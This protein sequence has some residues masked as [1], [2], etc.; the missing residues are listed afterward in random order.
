[1]K[2]KFN[3]TELKTIKHQPCTKCVFDQILNNR[4]CGLLPRI[5]LV[6]S[7]VYVPT[8]NF[9][10]IFYLDYESSI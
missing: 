9:S 10:D 6:D 8:G 7:Q 5:C 4:Y 1:M 3:L 2:I